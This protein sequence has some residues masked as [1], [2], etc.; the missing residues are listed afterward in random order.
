[1]E[2]DTG[3]DEIGLPTTILVE[4]VVL[5][6]YRI[7]AVQFE[8]GDYGAGVPVTWRFESYF[9][10][11]L[12]LMLQGGAKMPRPFFETRDSGPPHSRQQVI[13]FLPADG[14]AVGT[15]ATIA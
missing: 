2:V 15:A 4:V 7:L 14:V 11:P 12:L 10:S 5:P 13:Y 3:L 6:L 9:L 1:M 8:N